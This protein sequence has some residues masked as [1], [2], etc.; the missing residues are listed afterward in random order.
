[1]G[2]RCKRRLGQ[3]ALSLAGLVL[4]AGFL[5]ERPALAQSYKAARASERLFR[6]PRQFGVKIDSKKW[7]LRQAKQEKPRSVRFYRVATGQSEFV[8]LLNANGVVKSS[9]RQRLATLMRPRNSRKAKTPPRRLLEILAQVAKFVD[10]KP[11]HIISGYRKAGGHTH[12]T[13]RHTLGRAI[14]FRVP[15]FSNA[16]LR[17][18]C[19]RFGDVGVGY[20]PRSTFVHLDVRDK[21]AYWVDLSRPGEAPRYHRHQ[22]WMDHPE[23]PELDMDGLEPDRPFEPNESHGEPQEGDE[24]A[25]VAPKAKSFDAKTDDKVV[26]E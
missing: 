9:A 15:G 1:M 5:S 26:L 23:L 6:H 4:C 3:I 14:D 17:D 22:P 21:N 10:Y 19:R 16:K 7:K 11:I 20:Y 8:R 25:S 13:S 2:R 24:M 12:K 18:F